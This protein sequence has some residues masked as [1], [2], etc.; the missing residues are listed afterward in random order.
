M[1]KVNR[2][3]SLQ[4]RV[5]G[6]NDIQLLFRKLHQRQLQIVNLVGKNADFVA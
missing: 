5:S 3:C 4:V 2:L 6:Y 1:R